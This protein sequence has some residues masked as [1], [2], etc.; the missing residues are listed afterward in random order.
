[1]ALNHLVQALAAGRVEIGA[2]RAPRGL[3]TVRLTDIT[4]SRVD[5]ADQ[6]QVLSWLC[7][8]PAAAPATDVALPGD[9][10]LG[11]EISWTPVTPVMVRASTVNEAEPDRDRAVD[12]VPL[13]SGGTRQE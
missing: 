1:M 10:R 11:I 7:G 9:G 5:L 4:R 12:T 6:N 8:R 3:G 2:A 13:R